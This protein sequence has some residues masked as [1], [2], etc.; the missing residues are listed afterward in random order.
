VKEFRTLADVLPEDVLTPKIAAALI[1]RKEGF[2]RKRIRAKE[3]PARNRGGYLIRGEDFLSWLQGDDPK[4]PTVSGNSE[5]QALLTRAANG[6]SMSTPAI[7]AK[8]AS[9]SLP[10]G[11]VSR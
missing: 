11:I 9:L 6:A 3:I 10:K 4:K 5:A 2:I 8:M 1:H 7:A